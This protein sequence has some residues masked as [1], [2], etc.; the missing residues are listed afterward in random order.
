M[1]LRQTHGDEKLPVEPYDRQPSHD[2]KGAYVPP[3]FRLF[4]K[5]VVFMKQSTSQS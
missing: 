1:G 5:G 2:R 3:D 4:L